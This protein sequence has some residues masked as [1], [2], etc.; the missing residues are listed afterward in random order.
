MKEYD[1][2]SNFRHVLGVAPSVP[3]WKYPVILLHIYTMFWWLVNITTRG[4]VNKDSPIL[5]M[6]MQVKIVIQVNLDMTDHWTT[7]FCIWRTI[8]LVPVRCISSIR[9]MYTT[10]FAY[11]GPIF[12]APLS[13][14][15][16]SSPVPFKEAVNYLQGTWKSKSC[17]GWSFYEKIGRDNRLTGKTFVVWRSIIDK[18]LW[19]NAL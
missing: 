12:L 5:P 18:Y 3:L 6:T 13:L 8:C 1:S 15:Y 11:D 19:F 10:D 16:P 14:S 4:N 2:L 7:D 17:I 9:H